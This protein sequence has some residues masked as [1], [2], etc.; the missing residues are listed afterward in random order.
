VLR[1]T[2][3]QDL[4]WSLILGSLGLILGMIWQWPLIQ[5]GF[6]G[7]LF[8]QL[9]E[10]ERQEAARRLEGVRTYNLQQVH[11]L[12]QKGQALFIDA[13]PPEE[14]RELHI[15]G[16]LNLTTD[17][18]EGRTVPDMLK[19]IDPHRSIIV[20]CGHEDCHASLQVAELLQSRGF[21]Q[22]AVFL[23]GFRAWDEA[24]YPVDV[25]R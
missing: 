2:L 13:R 24:G 7:Q 1:T 22:V 16:A 21:T 12:Q 10:L 20:Y 11:T 23:G 4:K 19:N 9:K 14:Y 15:E 5:Q 8:F 18:L 3:I 17:Q 25:S 6:Q